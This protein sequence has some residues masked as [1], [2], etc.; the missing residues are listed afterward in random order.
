MI[1][2]L[3]SFLK[4]RS[5]KTLPCFFSFILVSNLIENGFGYYLAIKYNDNVWLYNIFIIIC[6]SYYLFILKEKTI[7]IKVRNIISKGQIVFI[8]LSILNMMFLQGFSQLNTITYNLGM[9]FVT[10][11]ILNYLKQLIDDVD[12]NYLNQ[13]IFYLCIGILLFYTTLFPVL[14][15]SNQFLSLDKDFAKVLYALV[16]L[17]NVLLI[18]SYLMAIFVGWKLRNL[19]IG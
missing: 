8:G 2:S 3:L 10:I 12:T 7:N 18:L 9:L 19:S 14:A 11:I 5:I 6:I 13:P 15:F 17:G 4:V 16:E 1:L